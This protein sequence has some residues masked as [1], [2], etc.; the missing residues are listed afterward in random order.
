MTREVRASEAKTQFGRLLDAVER[1]ETIVLTRRGRRVAR[2]VPEAQR[3]QRAIERAVENIK[4]VRQRTGKESLEEIL[5]W[6][7]EGHKY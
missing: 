3:D 6:R 4:G 5:S 7:H 1:G 2:L